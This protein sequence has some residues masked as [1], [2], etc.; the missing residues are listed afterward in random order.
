[1][2]CVCI[3]HFSE[4]EELMVINAAGE[5]DLVLRECHPWWGRVTDPGRVPFL[6][7]F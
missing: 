3:L 5:E 2:P 1:M 4:N 7:R 6:L